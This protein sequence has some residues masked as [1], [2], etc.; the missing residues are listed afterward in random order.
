MIINAF[1]MK[2][3]PQNQRPFFVSI[4]LDDSRG[5][6]YNQYS[7]TLNIQPLSYIEYNLWWRLQVWQSQQR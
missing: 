7:I 6:E 4:F 1:P 2:K 3:R 5:I